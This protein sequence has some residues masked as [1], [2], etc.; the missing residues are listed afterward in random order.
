[1]RVMGQ[2]EYTCFGI[3][4]PYGLGARCQSA[5]MRGPGRATRACGRRV[6]HAQSV[7]SVNKTTGARRLCAH[8]PIPYVRFTVFAIVLHTP[9]P[10]MAS[11]SIPASP[12]AAADA[13]PTFTSHLDGP[14]PA[15]PAITGTAM[16]PPPPPPP[17]LPPPPPPPYSG[18]SDARAPA[19]A[20]G[21]PVGVSMAG[22]PPA[23]LGVSIAPDVVVP[24]PN[25]SPPP[26]TGRLASPSAVI[27]PRA[28]TRADG[29]DWAKYVAEDE[30]MAEVMLDSPGT[31]AAR[32]ERIVRD[33]DVHDAGANAAVEDE[34]MAAAVAHDQGAEGVQAGTSTAAA[35][36]V[37]PDTLA[38]ALASTTLGGAGAP[39]SPV[40]GNERRS[41]RF[42][43]DVRVQYSER[44]Q[45]QS[46]SSAEA[47]T[48]AA[49]E[50][51]AGPFVRPQ[52]LDE[53]LPQD[54]AGPLEDLLALGA[55]NNEVECDLIS[56]T[57][58]FAR[59]LVDRAL[60][61]RDKAIHAACEAHSTQLS[62]VHFMRREA[63][64]RRA[65]Y[66]NA[67]E[68]EDAFARTEHLDAVIDRM[69]GDGAPA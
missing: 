17:P 25:V 18:C 23:A 20:P 46:C 62:A 24:P 19:F 6:V 21:P 44:A 30:R 53:T 66:H 57:N 45:E 69:T 13:A 16:V 55:Y 26:Y 59:T 67:G 22:E 39:V 50:M 65:R 58:E 28:L 61:Y 37:R 8:E 5:R 54:M 63:G 11:Q 35:P 33:V 32:L 10:S 56:R 36:D 40:E 15:Y 43:R 34:P 12:S 48:R 49:A 2:G 68:P 7:C 41:A 9:S 29:F 4:L 42:W 52:S 60:Y 51:T 27:V 64:R 38:E 3:L 47:L 31:M 14:P 1:V